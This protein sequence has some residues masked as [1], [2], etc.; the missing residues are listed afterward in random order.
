[1]RDYEREYHE[2]PA[3]GSVVRVLNRK[4]QRPS[5][6]LTQELRAKVS[7]DL[8]AGKPR[9][10]ISRETGLSLTSITRVKLGTQGGRS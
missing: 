7:K 5:V 2:A 1:M 9:S 4:P 3:Y 6:F 8:R 10:E